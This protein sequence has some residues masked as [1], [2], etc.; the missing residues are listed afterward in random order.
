M[1]VEGKEVVKY[2]KLILAPG[3]KPKRL[4]IDGVDLDGVF[5][6]RQVPDAEKINKGTSHHTSVAR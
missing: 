4:P 5:V 6:L 2:T 3:S 1:T